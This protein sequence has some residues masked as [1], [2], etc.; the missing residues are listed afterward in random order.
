MNSNAYT[1]S[2][3]LSLTALLLA[4]QVTNCMGGSDISLGTDALNNSGAGA[5]NDTA[6]KANSMG[7]VDSGAGGNTNTG[8]VLST[9]SGGLGGSGNPFPFPPGS[10]GIASGAGG[11]AQS[12][13]GANGPCQPKLVGLVRD[14]NSYLSPVNPH[15]DFETFRGLGT[16][17]LVASVLGADGAPVFAQPQ[18]AGDVQLTTAE[19]FHL[20]YSTAHPTSSTFELDLDN[21]PVSAHMVKTFD[22]ITKKVSY[23]STQFF[24][25]DG[26][27]TQALD[28]PY[29]E[30]KDGLS[31]AGNL[32]PFHNYHFTFELNTRFIY[33]KGQTLEFYG[34]DDL[35]VFINNQLVID[36]GGLHPQL[37]GSVNL[38]TVSGLTV[39]QEYPL[40]VFHAER[41]TTT[42]NYK[43]STNVE[44]SNCEV[45]RR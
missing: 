19:N 2:C 5:P 26:R 3:L 38:D 10:G 7:G 30:N 28:L 15:P 9:P 37:F 39:G 45:I 25:I 31:T 42:S 29:G 6:S 44:F 41:A 34:D 32:P 36:L 40:S 13:T 22:P 1:R 24:P 33:R 14:F 8:G 17:G 16:L 35:W 4:S 18:P 12:G 11:A 27:G 23:E 20:W 21:P 43:L